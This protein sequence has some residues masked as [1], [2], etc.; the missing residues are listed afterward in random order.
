ML[1]C[2]DG[3]YLPLVAKY[4]ASSNAPVFELDSTL[5]PDVQLKVRK[6]SPQAYDAM[7]HWADEARKNTAGERSHDGY[8]TGHPNVREQNRD[9]MA[10]EYQASP[11][12]CCRADSEP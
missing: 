7:P 11:S 2:A 1:A 8:E 3:S 4:N 5:C 12:F 6:P 9:H 10:I